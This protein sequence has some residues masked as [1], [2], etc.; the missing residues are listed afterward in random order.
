VSSGDVLLVVLAAVLVLL[1]S[2][3]SGADAAVSRVSAVV[4][5][6]LE[7]EGRRGSRSLA[8]L[9]ADPARSLGPLLLVRVVAEVGAAG[10]VTLVF[11]HAVGTGFAALGLAVLVMAI[12]GFV[13]VD[14]APRTVGRQQTVPFALAVSGPAIAVS[15]AL[16]PLTKVL[17][18]IG[19]A[20]TPGV[21]FRNGPFDSEAELRAL[22]D[23]AESRGVVAQREA[24]M[25]SGVF[26]LGDTIAREVMVPRPDIVFIESGK[27]VRQGLTLA[28]RSGFSRIPVTGEGIDDIIGFAYVKDLARRSLDARASRGQ[29]VETLARKPFFVPDSK[30]VDELLREMQASRQ[31]IAVVVDEYGGT[32]GLVTIE[33]ILEEI[34]GEIADEYDADEVAPVEQLGDGKAR[35]VSRVLVE[36]IEDLFD[37]ELPN[38]HDVETVG[39]LIAASLGRVPIPGATVEISG[40][41]FTAESTAGRRNRIGTVLVERLGE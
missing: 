16:Q 17:V 11:A 7:R 23:E 40:L 13:V 27:T 31:H 36:E 8:R 32:S 1:A 22:V 12:V 10:A 41:R 20:L 35:V 2:L 5:A 9:V 25:I 6:D 30:P 24:D 3:L 29:R 33:D 14:V 21:G 15:R 38:E 39:G 19:N 34:V 4:A 26:E 28:L 18:V 37:V